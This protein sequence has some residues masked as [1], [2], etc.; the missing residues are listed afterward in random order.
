MQVELPCFW[1]KVTEKSL[2]KSLRLF[3]LKTGSKGVDGEE[4]EGEGEQ[5]EGQEERNHSQGDFCS[6]AG[7][8][9]VKLPPESTSK[10]SLTHSHPF[11]IPTEL[12]AI[13]AL[14]VSYCGIL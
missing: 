12:A 5:W 13:P 9:G 7:V 1:A 6:P 10:M 14:I 3:F 4:E 8:C 11:P 2:L